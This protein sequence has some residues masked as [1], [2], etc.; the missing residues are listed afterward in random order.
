MFDLT[1][2]ERSYLVLKAGESETNESVR[3]RA[4]KLGVLSR[5]SSNELEY[6]KKR[7]SKELI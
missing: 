2:V 4:C 3:M 6:F 5:L 1:A 7:I